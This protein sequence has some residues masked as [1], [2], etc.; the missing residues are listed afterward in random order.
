MPVHEYQKIFDKKS[1]EDTI[2]KA[3]E[4]RE[5]SPALRCKAGIGLTPFV[6]TFI[7]LDSGRVSSGNGLLLVVCGLKP[8]RCFHARK[9]GFKRS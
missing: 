4:G 2:K 8:E 1:K 6:D 3:G 7:I 5:N 9:N